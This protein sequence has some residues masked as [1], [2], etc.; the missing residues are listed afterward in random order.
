MDA[1]RPTTLPSRRKP[2]PTTN[3]L[4]WPRRRI[5]PGANPRFLEA[6][7]LEVTSG[8]FSEWDPPLVFFTVAATGVAKGCDRVKLFQVSRPRFAGVTL[9]SASILPFDRLPPNFH[10]PPVCSTVQGSSRGLGIRIGV[11]FLDQRVII[12][13]RIRI[14]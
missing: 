7:S 8:R 11:V 12:R 9:L 5:S 1:G 13:L 10:Y 6:L 14:K 3:P 4:L 2:R